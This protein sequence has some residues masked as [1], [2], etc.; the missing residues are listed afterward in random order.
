METATTAQTGERESVALVDWKNPPN[1]EDLKADLNSAK[2]DHSIQVAKI[3]TWLENLN[4]EGAAKPKVRKGAS[5]VQPKLIRKQA[6]WR[7]SSL[8]EPFLSTPDIFEVSPITWED[9]K[10]AVQNALVLNNQ[11]NTKINKVAFIDEYVRTAVDEGTVTL[12]VGWDFEEEEYDALEP[13]YKFKPDTTVLPMFTHLTQMFSEDRNGFFRDVPDPLQKAFEYF[14]QTGLPVIP[15]QVGAR[16][17]KK[18]RTVKNHPTL[19]VC[20]Y[21]NLI[22]DPTCKGDLDAAKFII[23]SYE[24][25]LSDLEKDDRNKNL[26]QIDTENS[27]AL[28]APDHAANDSSSFSFTDKPRKQIVVHEY[29]GYWDIDGTGTV[30]PI[31]A[32]WVGDTLIRL[33]ENPF[34]DKALPFVNVQYLP[35]RRKTHG[36]PDGHLLTDNQKIAGAVTRGMIDLMGKSANGQTAFRKGALDAVNRRKYERGQDYELN[37]QVHPEQA[38]HTHKYSDIPSS[39]QFMLELQNYDAESMTGVKAFSGQGISGNGL[40]DS[41]TAARGALDAASKREMGVLRRLSAGLVAAGRKIIAMNAEFLDE[42]AVVRVT[43][44]EFVSVRPDDLAG[45]FDLKLTIST[46]EDDN[47]KAAELAF[48]LQTLGPNEDP[49]V[50]KMILVDIA[51]LRK[52]PD[53]A[54]KLESFQPQPDPMQQR[55]QELEMLKLEAEIKLLFGKADESEASAILD[56]AKAITEGAKKENLNSNT[57]KQTL[58]FVEQES[59]VTQ[60]RELQKQGE[61][62]RSNMQLEAQKAHLKSREEGKNQFKEF[63][64]TKS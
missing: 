39:A 58:D 38:I 26:H 28:G 36:E 54:K 43:N 3:D 1:V 8:S 57:D 13:V 33:E 18:T 42:D 27:S 20:D 31:V 30:K 63:L 61:Q 11:F 53:L 56:R 50:R 12:R 48:M 49:E 16:P 51:R 62:A 32:V 2:S 55:I 46:A 10:A 25:S 52:M 35:V 45:N 60:E 23:Y 41:A 6:E 22:I 64:A 14:Q 21:R 5:K 40:G 47:A 7:Y 44:E 17:V 29:W 4:V 24:S 59:G 34:P 9:K 15:R 19:D 37:G